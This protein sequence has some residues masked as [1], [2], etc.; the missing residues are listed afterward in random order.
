MSM[1]A[2]LTGVHNSCE[3]FPHQIV[4]CEFAVFDVKKYVSQF[5]RDRSDRQALF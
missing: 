2:F 1:Y 4:V 5:F 3:E